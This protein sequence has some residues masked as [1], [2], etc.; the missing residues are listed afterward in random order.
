MAGLVPPATAPAPA[1]DTTQKPKENERADYLNLP[2]PI[3][4]DEISREAYSESLFHF[5][6]VSDYMLRALVWKI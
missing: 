3:P 4:Y 1:P 2:C 5:V 6:K